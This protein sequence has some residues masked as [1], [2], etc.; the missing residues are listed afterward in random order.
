MSFD[1]EYQVVTQSQFRMPGQTTQAY[2]A[3]LPAVLG[4]VHEVQLT[5]YIGAT[6]FGATGIATNGFLIRIQELQ[7]GRVYTPGYP[8]GPV[9]FLVPTAAPYGETYVSMYKDNDKV[10]FPRDNAP[11]V[12]QFS[13]SFWDL[14]GAPAAMPE[15][16][17]KFYVRSWT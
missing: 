7:T 4:A 8:S 11:F 5:H 12:R 1:V 9:E 6:A 16:L 3:A 15:H 14:S 10:V 17:L 13:L 2:T